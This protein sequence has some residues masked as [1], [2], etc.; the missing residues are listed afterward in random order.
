MLAFTP[1]YVFAL[2]RPQK[3]QTMLRTELCSFFRLTLWKKLDYMLFMPKY[4]SAIKGPK[5]GK[6]CY[7]ITPVFPINASEKLH[8]MLAFVPIYAFVLKGPKKGHILLCM[9]KILPAEELR[10]YQHTDK[11]L[12]GVNECVG[13][14]PSTGG[15]VLLHT[16]RNMSRGNSMSDELET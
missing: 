1:K 15:N 11:I 13:L 9:L 16:Y 8:Y 12:R 10:A 4:A 14:V 6:L 2:K 3:R 7:R 5:K